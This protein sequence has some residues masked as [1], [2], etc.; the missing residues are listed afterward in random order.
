MKI[1]FSCTSD[2]KSGTEG[3]QQI[4]YIT[5]LEINQLPYVFVTKIYVFCTKTMY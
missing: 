2:M 4:Y 1:D 3:P 5:H